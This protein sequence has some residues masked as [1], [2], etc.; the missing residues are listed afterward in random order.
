MSYKGLKIGLAL[1]GGGARGLAHIGVLQALEERNIIPD[2]I[3][4]CSMGAIV[5]ALY[6]AGK[7]PKELREIFKDE[8]PKKH[9]KL[10]FNTPGLFDM[11]GLKSM[12]EHYVGT[13]SFESLKKELHISVAN[14]NTGKSEIISS[15]NQLFEYILA[16]SSIPLVFGAKEING[17][18]YVDGGLFDNLPTETLVGHCHRI[19][20]SH[21]NPNKIVHEFPSSKSILERCFQLTIEQNVRISRGFCD[22]FIEPRDIRHYSI[23]D[24]NKGNEIINLGYTST[25][26]V[27]DQFIVPDL[28]DELQENLL[29]HKAPL[30]RRKLILKKISRK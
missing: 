18:T 7:T 19:I 2:I 17:Q 20:G 23:W 6:C 22:Y 15:G 29:N 8:N 30:N 26:K 1:S 27:I 11:V 25:L 9:I 21:V 14:L 12:L 3:S 24:F 4:G 13:N 28:F 10:N 16:S 5:G